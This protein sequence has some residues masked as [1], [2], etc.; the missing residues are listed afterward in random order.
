MHEVIQ[1]LQ[2]NVR[3][4]SVTMIINNLI[5]YYSQKSKRKSNPSKIYAHKGDVTQ[6]GHI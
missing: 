5:I 4:F 2:A 6:D 3:C 1:K